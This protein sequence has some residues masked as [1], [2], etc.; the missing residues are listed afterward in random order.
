MGRKVRNAIKIYHNYSYQ[1]QY[2]GNV[3]NEPLEVAH[4]TMG[5][6]DT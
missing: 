6:S 5:F 2:K 1:F 4:G 3:P